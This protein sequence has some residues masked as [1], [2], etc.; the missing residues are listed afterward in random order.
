MSS[1]RIGSWLSA[2]SNLHQIGKLEQIADRIHWETGKQ[3]NRNHKKYTN[4]RAI[5]R[6]SYYKSPN[7]AKH[8][9]KVWHTPESQ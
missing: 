7:K 3:E 9:T 8:Q 2:A 5:I 1:R 4:P 6:N